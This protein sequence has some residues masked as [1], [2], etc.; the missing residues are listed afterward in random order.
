MALRDF[1]SKDK[2]SSLNEQMDF[3]SVETY[4]EGN[5]NMV[6]NGSNIVINKSSSST[7]IINQSDH[8]KS[9]NVVIISGQEDSYISEKDYFNQI[10]IKDQIRIFYEVSQHTELFENIQFVDEEGYFYEQDEEGEKLIEFISDEKNQEILLKYLSD[11]NISI[12]DL[13]QLLYD[14]EHDYE[15]DYELE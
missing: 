12:R 6:V 1:F 10:D 8:G 7:V 14:E 11:N 13:M 5:N 3:S 2:E 4:I 9:Q 15:E